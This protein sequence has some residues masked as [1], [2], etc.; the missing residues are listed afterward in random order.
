MQKQPGLLVESGG[1]GGRSLLMLTQAEHHKQPRS[2]MVAL[3]HS[4]PP[5]T[6]WFNISNNTIMWFPNRE[7]ELGQRAVIS[8]EGQ[9]G[10]GPVAESEQSKGNKCGIAYRQHIRD[11]LSL[12]L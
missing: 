7:G 5:N 1:G 2:L 4:S 6:H 10:L 3:K 8:C 12:C 9:R 11:R